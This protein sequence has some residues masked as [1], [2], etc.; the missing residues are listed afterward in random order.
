VGTTIG[1]AV[2]GVVVGLLAGAFGLLAF[3]RCRRPRNRHDSREDMTRDNHLI[4]HPP[5]SARATSVNSGRSPLSAGGS[6]LEYIVEP[7]AMPS[8]P[9]DSGAPLLG[10]Q[11]SSAQAP[12][13]TSASGL[14]DPAD[15][16]AAARRQNVYVVHHDGGRAP[17][18]VYTEEGAEVVEL[19]PR[20]PANSSSSPSAPSA[21]SA[22]S[23][24]DASREINRRRDPKATPR[25]G[26]RG[27]RSS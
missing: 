1:A 12:D 27:G 23:E 10:Q 24:S 9:S 8:P 26:T 20:Y 25:K 6:G 7:F 11:L 19:P 15:Q 5:Q 21:P 13:A 22:T 16:N 3:V 18:T 14:T 17:V 4:A 2:G